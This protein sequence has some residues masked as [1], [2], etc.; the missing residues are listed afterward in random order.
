MNILASEFEGCACLLCETSANG[1]AAYFARAFWEPSLLVDELRAFQH[2]QEVAVQRPALG[3]HIAQAEVAYR[4]V[5]KFYASG[6]VVALCN[7]SGSI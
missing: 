3:L 4:L 7:F 1:D 5:W 6:K 2:L